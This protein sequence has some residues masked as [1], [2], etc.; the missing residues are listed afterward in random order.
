M[1]SLKNDAPALIARFHDAF[2]LRLAF[3][4]LELVQLAL[5]HLVAELMALYRGHAD[6]P[7]RDYYRAQETMFRRIR[8]LVTAAA[9]RFDRDTALRRLV[10]SL[11]S[12]VGAMLD[13]PE[14]N[15]TDDAR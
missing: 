7:L 15:P 12:Q 2:L 6:A 9:P 5:W 3:T 11:H 4:E 13:V 1:C 14:P 8:Y 10:S